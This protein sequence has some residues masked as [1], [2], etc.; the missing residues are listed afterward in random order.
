M[1]R[2]ADTSL[3]L[4]M[5]MPHAV[6]LAS[7]ASTKLLTPRLL[8]YLA[9]DTYLIAVLSF[10]YPLVWTIGLLQYYRNG[11]KQGEESDN[12]NK[13][14]SGA[15][16]TPSR[17]RRLSSSFFPRTTP[18]RS[19]QK[20]L[21]AA[22]TPV[23]RAIHKSDDE[24]EYNVEDDATYWL[25]YWFVYALLLA[26]CRLTILLPIVGRVLAKYALLSTFLR[27]LQLVLYLWLFGVPLVTPELTRETRPI[28]LLYQRAVP[29]VTAI[30]KAVSHAI[31]EAFWQS[32]VDKASSFLDIAVMIKLL[33]ESTKDWLIHVL[34]EARPV[35]PP[36]ITLFMPGFITEYGVVYVKTLVPCAKCSQ[37]I[38]LSQKMQWLEYWVLHGLLS[39]FLTWWAPILWWIPFS[40]HAIFLLWCN[41]QIP[42]TTRK[43]YNAFEEEL[44]AFGLLEKGEK[45]LQVEQTVTASVFRRLASSLP[46]A[47]D[48]DGSNNNTTNGGL[49]QQGEQEESNESQDSD[50]DVV[51]VDDDESDDGAATDDNEGKAHQSPQELVSDHSWSSDEN[52][53]N[54]NVTTRRRSTRQR[55][56]RS[57]N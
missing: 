30:Y 6:F 36:A 43:C 3:F 50:G 14:N 26:V 39:C 23:R 1:R 42:N 40:T 34:E 32:V 28:P 55:K 56:P 16:K 47:S 21:R 48:A 10:W 41:L 2:I 53:V 52:K 46:S 17:R 27:E 31:P 11:G 4:A 5:L 37:A 29:V 45:N 51:M 35:L 13:R 8:S 33:S 38:S 15:F 24:E 44:Q 57:V 20:W 9:A 18:T 7:V 25:E 12:K 54:S 19:V 49:V 22:T